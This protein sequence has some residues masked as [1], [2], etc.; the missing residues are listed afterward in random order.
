M[1]LTAAMILS[2]MCVSVSAEEVYHLKNGV[3][4]TTYSRDEYTP[5]ANI[6]RTV[7][8]SFDTQ[9]STFPNST[10]IGNNLSLGR[11]ES[12]IEILFTE[13]PESVCYFSL[14]DMTDDEYITDGTNHLQGPSRIGDIVVFS[15]LTGGHTY[16]IRMAGSING[17][18][19]AG[20]ITSY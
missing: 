14:Y 4:L 17:T 3:T 9:I 10:L 15:D 8:T 11:S 5:R 16:R 2:V 1:C 12:T 18:T 19:V 13:G 20:T 7:N 6:S